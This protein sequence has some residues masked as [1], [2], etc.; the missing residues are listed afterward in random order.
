MYFC[1]CDAI[2]S[3][4]RRVFGAIADDNYLV[5]LS[6]ESFVI[7]LAEHWGEVNALHP[8]REGNTRT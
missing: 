1:Q 8:F 5:G 3:E 4:A 7:R 2:G 6:R